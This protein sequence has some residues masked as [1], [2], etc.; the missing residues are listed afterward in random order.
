MEGNG[1]ILVALGIV[2]V[3]MLVGLWNNW[4]FIGPDGYNLTGKDRP[5]LLRFYVT[6]FRHPIDSFNGRAFWPKEKTIKKQ[7]MGFY[8][9]RDW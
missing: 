3:A 4:I 7:T 8:S 5:S 2:V 6:L 9:H 1:D